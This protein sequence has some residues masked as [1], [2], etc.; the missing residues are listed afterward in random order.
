[1]QVGVMQLT[2]SMYSCW[3]L[4]LSEALVCPFLCPTRY[5][6][7]S[8]GVRVDCS[9]CDWCMRQWCECS[10]FA[11]VSYPARRP[12]TSASS[13]GETQRGT[14]WSKKRPW[15][16]WLEREQTRLDHEGR[17]RIKR[18]WSP[19][20]PRPDTRILSST[21]AAPIPRRWSW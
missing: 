11:L 2:S 9:F 19:A 3:A 16:V 5:S 7:E 12:C 6:S 10:S 8:R 14:T 15:I 20:R 21:S 17:S 4:R 1:M 13:M 18:G